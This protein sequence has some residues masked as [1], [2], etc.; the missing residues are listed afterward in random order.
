MDRTQLELLF[1]ADNKLVNQLNHEKSLIIG[2]KGSGKTTLLTSVRLSDQKASHYYLPS[3][4]LFAQ[5]VREINS[6][7]TGVVFVEQV[8]RLWDFVLWGIVFHHVAVMY[9]DPELTAF[10]RALGVTEEQAPYE[11]IATM[12]ATIKSFPPTDWP[13]PEKIAYK[14]IGDISFL[15]AKQIAAEILEKRKARVYLL[16]DSL[17]DFK[18]NIPSFGTALAGLLRCIGDFNEP[19]I[20][21]VV[22]RCC[23]P[24]E[25]YFDYMQLSTNPLKDFRTA[26]LLHWSAGELI[27][28]SAVRYSKFLK[29]YS[30]DFYNSEIKKLQLTKREHLQKFWDLIFPDMVTSRLEVQEKPIAY[31]L[32]HTQLLPRHFIFFL[33]EIISSSLKQNNNKAYGIQSSYIRNGIRQAEPYIFA[34]IIEA[35]TT[36]EHQPQQACEGV[37]KEL[38]TTFSWSEFDK[39]SPKVTKLGIPGVS[40]GPELMRMLTEIGAVGRVVGESPRYREGVFEYMLPNKLSF[41][42][43]D[44]FCVHPVFSE[45]CRVN[46]DYPDPKAI[47]TYWAGITDEDLAHWM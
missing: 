11:V 18:L 24:A 43:I 47:Y 32:R 27:H 15:K 36:P 31:I 14:R 4:D 46:I 35:Y 12:L 25:R 37:L 42:E 3:S 10:C 33:N 20:R 39:V 7:S 1:D 2:R 34:Q 26:M 21:S 23:L 44:R 45:V 30:P 38:N 19:R 8:S 41:S 17:E 5:I 40:N 13:L 28:L 9:K 29:E 6:L 22:L 16:M